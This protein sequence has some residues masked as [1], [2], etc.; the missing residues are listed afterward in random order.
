MVT[1]LLGGRAGSQSAIAHDVLPVRE[2][3]TG[4][5]EALGLAGG[6]QFAEFTKAVGI[7]PEGDAG[8]LAGGPQC[9]RE[10]RPPLQGLLG[11]FPLEARVGNDRAPRQLDG[12]PLAETV[13]PFFVRRHPAGFNLELERIAID[14]AD[15]SL[16]APPRGGKFPPT[17]QLQLHPI[18]QF[19]QRHEADPSATHAE[20]QFFSLDF[21]ADRGQAMT[22]GLRRGG[23]LL[24][25]FKFG[26]QPREL[27]AL[28]Q[29]FGPQ[30]LQLRLALIELRLGLGRGTIEAG[31]LLLGLLATLPGG[32]KFRFGGG[33]GRQECGPLAVSLGQRAECVGGGGEGGQVGGWLVG[34]RD[35]RRFEHR[36]G[37]GG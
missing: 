24:G 23:R 8:I 6:L 17:L 3:A 9:H 32:G 5:E 16:V 1:G 7:G 34:A 19:A 27:F 10:S 22:D 37:R 11:G 33:R 31:E 14:R 25:L 28:T 4:D 26:E 30:G 13:D 36:D 35:R 18:E 2:G 21:L 29:E 20:V 15:P 12:V